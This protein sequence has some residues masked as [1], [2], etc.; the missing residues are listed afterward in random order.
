MP[1]PDTLL[2]FDY[3]GTLSLE[4]PRFA[5]PENLGV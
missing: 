4:M 3:S 5:R 2:I 1:Q